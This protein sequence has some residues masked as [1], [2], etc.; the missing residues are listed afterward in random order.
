MKK[1]DDDFKE[2]LRWLFLEKLSQLLLTEE[3]KENHSIH[4]NS[5]VNI[6]RVGIYYFSVQ[7]PG[8]EYLFYLRESFKR[9]SVLDDGTEIEIPH[10]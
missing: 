5:I 4:F 10:S 2:D 6:N 3:V 7:L 8:I 1:V 9:L